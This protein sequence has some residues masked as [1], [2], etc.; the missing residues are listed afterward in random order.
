MTT[1]P[2]IIQGGMGVAVSNWS[3]ARAVSSLGQLGVVSGT[4][5]AVIL[6]R[7]LQMGDPGGHMR[8]ALENFPVPAVARRVL[9]DH[10]VPGGKRPEAPFRGVP[11]PGLKPAPALVDLT[12]TANFVEVF[13]AKHGH[14]GPVGINFLE[15]VQ[16]ST[17]LV[18]H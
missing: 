9:A 4:A 8:R 2:Q 1:H 15:K 5:L 10:F 16:F 7:R 11:L 6:S 3:L 12:V 14:S 18:A 13:L 17:L